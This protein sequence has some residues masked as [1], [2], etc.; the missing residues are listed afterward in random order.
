MIVGKLVAIGNK[1]SYNVEYD[2]GSPRVFTYTY[3]SF[4]EAVQAYG[5]SLVYARKLMG[6]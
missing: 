5:K 4:S 3:D 2:T 6:G 1:W